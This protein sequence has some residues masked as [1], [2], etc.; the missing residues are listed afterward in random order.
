MNYVPQIA[1]E[2]RNEMENLK[3]EKAKR[4][5]PDL[6]CSTFY[7]FSAS[8]FVTIS[9]GFTSNLNAN[10]NIYLCVLHHD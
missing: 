1:S 2:N 6:K 7:F 5:N 8:K 4:I 10:R 9:T 3:T